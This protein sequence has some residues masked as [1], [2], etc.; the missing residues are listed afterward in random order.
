[1]KVLFVP[2]SPLPPRLPSSS[3]RAHKYRNGEE[4]VNLSNLE[5]KYYYRYLMKPDLQFH[6]KWKCYVFLSSEH[7][8]FRIRSSILSSSSLF[9]FPHKY[10]NRE[11]VNLSNLESRCYCR[12]L[13]KFK[14]KC[15]VFLSSKHFRIRFSIPSSS[16][17]SFLFSSC[18]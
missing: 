9:L 15:Y 8:H 5:S 7:K 16:S 13:M 2:R 6:I 1:M 12:Y 11:S 18:T 14:W 3:L 17:S 10:R 4:F